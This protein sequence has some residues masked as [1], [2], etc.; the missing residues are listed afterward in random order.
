MGPELAESLA[1]IWHAPG[2]MRSMRVVRIRELRVGV[3]RR[4]QVRLTKKLI[5]VRRTRG[6]WVRRRCRCVGLSRKILRWQL[7]KARRG[8]SDQDQMFALGPWLSLMRLMGVKVK[9]I[10]FKGEAFRLTC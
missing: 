6:L 10:I 8:V 2:V 9:R 3:G 7:I 4:S 5:R 1:L